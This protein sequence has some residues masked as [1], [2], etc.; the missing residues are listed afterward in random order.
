MQQK[1]FHQGRCNS[2]R[3]FHRFWEK[4]NFF[5]LRN[6]QANLAQENYAVKLK[7]ANHDIHVKA[8]EKKLEE[9]SMFSIS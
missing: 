8:A 1:R 6:D 5:R 3:Q 9:A 2:D 7:E 4:S